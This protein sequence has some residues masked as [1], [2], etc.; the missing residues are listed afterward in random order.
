[1]YIRSKVCSFLE[2]V[3]KK[4]ESRPWRGSL[5]DVFQGGLV[6]PHPSYR[7]KAITECLSIFEK[8]CQRKKLNNHYALKLC[9]QFA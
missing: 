6:R 3:L 1:M 7:T 9:K 2:P 5:F 8:R 4:F